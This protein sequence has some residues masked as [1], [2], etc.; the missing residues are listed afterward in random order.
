M[1]TKILFRLHFKNTND[2]NSGNK[3]LCPIRQDVQFCEEDIGCPMMCDNQLIGIAS[4]RYNWRTW[5]MKMD[6]G[7]LDVEF[8]YLFLNWEYVNWIK[9]VIGTNP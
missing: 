9:Q 3:W 8:R 5:A 2:V 1:H 7:N 4:Q 6:C